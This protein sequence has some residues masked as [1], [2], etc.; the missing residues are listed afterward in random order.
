[1]KHIYKESQTLIRTASSHDLQVK[2]IQNVPTDKSI[3]GI[4]EESVLSNLSSFHPITSLPPDIMHDILEGIMPKLTG[5]LLHTVVS[6][7][8]CSA[9]KI[10][11][12]INKFIYGTNDRRNHPPVLKE[13]DILEKRIPGKCEIL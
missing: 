4:N 11:Q 2:Q 5:C 10:C 8:L 6:N 1:M 7:R 13:K 3:Y 12:R 9:S